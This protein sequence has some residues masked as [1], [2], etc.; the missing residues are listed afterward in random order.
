MIKLYD[1]IKLEIV[2]YDEHRWQ[3]RYPDRI[4]ECFWIP[5]KEQGDTR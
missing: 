2:G 1:K 3:V 4:D 5:R